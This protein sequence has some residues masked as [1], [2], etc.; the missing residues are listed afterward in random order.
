MKVAKT[1][2]FVLTKQVVNIKFIFC[3]DV[4]SLHCLDVTTKVKDTIPR[5]ISVTWQGTVHYTGALYT[6]DSFGMSIQCIKGMVVF[7]LDRSDAKCKQWFDWASIK[8]VISVNPLDITC[9][10]S[11]VRNK[12]EVFGVTPWKWEGPCL[13]TVACVGPRS[14][15]AWCRTV[16][17]CTSHQRLVLYHKFCINTHLSHALEQVA[18][19]LLTGCIPWWPYAN[20]IPGSTQGRLP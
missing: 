2:I 7:T 10:I 20:H 3:T 6:A 19:L 1:H 5:M 4:Q 12:P 14:T 15:R 11:R 13:G 18:T 8:H 17:N 16:T 9:K